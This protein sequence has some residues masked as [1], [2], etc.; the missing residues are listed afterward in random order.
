VIAGEWG[1]DASV[2]E[3]VR[4]V[5]KLHPNAEFEEYSVGGLS[6]LDARVGTHPSG[7]GIYDTVSLRKAGKKNG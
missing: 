6:F 4:N 2:V 3:E 1:Q 5:L 7:C